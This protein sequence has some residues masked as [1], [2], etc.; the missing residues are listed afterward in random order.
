MSGPTERVEKVLA[1]EAIGC[2]PFFDIFP[3]SLL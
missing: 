1:R 2:T 3:P